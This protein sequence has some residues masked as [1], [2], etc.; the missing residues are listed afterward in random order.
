[1]AKTSAEQALSR[2]Y[3]ISRG[4]VSPEY[5]KKEA[6]TGKSTS[7]GGRTVSDQDM[8]LL[9]KAK[10]GAVRK[11]AKGGTAKKKK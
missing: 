8:K 7:R 6:G 11:M 4:L 1:M 2:I 5:V 10:G 9:N 3:A